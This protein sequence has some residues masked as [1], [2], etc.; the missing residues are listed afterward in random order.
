MEQLATTKVRLPGGDRLTP[1]RLQVVG[2]EFGMA[3]GF[4]R[5]HYLVEQAFFEDRDRPVFSD[6]FLHRVE[7]VT[8]FHEVPLFAALHEPIYCQGT[9]AN[10]AAHRV[11][12]EFPQF[13]PHELGSLFTGEMIYPWMFEQQFCLQPLQAAA[14]LVAARSTGRRSMT[15]TGWGECQAKVAAVV[16]HDDMYVDA[17]GSL[18]TAAAREGAAGVG[19]QRVRARRCIHGR[20]AGIRPAGEDGQRRTLGQATRR[21]G[22]GDEGGFHGSGVGA[23]AQRRDRRGAAGVAQRPQL[24]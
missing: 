15:W 5:V 21:S 9:A 22:H 24:L 19:D 20:K 4:E 17:V 10:W 8:S 1:E 18:E 7:E 16:Y 14:E 23:D 13:D 12:D 11:R 2:I 6:G 3:E